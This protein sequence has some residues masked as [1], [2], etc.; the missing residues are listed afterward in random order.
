MLDI[1]TSAFLVV[2]SVVGY[3]VMVERRAELPPVT[4]NIDPEYDYVIGEYLHL[5]PN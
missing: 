1:R 3:Y 4:E 5:S 2:L